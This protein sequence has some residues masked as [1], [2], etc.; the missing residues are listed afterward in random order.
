V[1][2]LQ[3]DLNVFDIDQMRPAHVLPRCGNSYLNANRTR[4]LR[5]T[6][7]SALTAIGRQPQSVEIIMKTIL[8]AAVAAVTLGMTGVALAGEPVLH[9]GV[10]GQMAR[11]EQVAPQQRPAYLARNEQVSPQQRPTYLG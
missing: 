11:N 9:H 10:Q 2:W 8:M 4:W 3:S 7:A 5:K 1:N 6:F